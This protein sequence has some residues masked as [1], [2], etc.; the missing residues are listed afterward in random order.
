MEAVVKNEGRW[1][2]WYAGL[3]TAQPYGGTESYDMAEQFLAG[4]AV[5]DWGC[6][7]GWFRSVHVG[8]YV[9]VDGTQTV[10][11]DR[12]GDLTEYVSECEGI[13]LRHVLEH[14][15]SWAEVFQNALASATVRIVVL[16]FTPVAELGS[17][18][19]E[20]KFWPEIGVPD[21]SLDMA[22]ILKFSEAAGWRLE[23]EQ[24]FK[25][26]TQ[27]RTETLLVFER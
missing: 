9:G 4:L 6:G 18:T 2:T 5:E 3:K 15:Y 22:D 26:A 1:A 24:T 14:N 25:S 16:L 17:G 19:A 10:F 21:L 7:K 13:L 23:V 11:S 20:L 8:P 27:Y 12:V